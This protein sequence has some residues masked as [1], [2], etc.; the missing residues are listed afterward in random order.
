VIIPEYFLY[1]GVAANLAY[2]ASSSSDP[3]RFDRAAMR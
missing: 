3:E 1:T 2:A